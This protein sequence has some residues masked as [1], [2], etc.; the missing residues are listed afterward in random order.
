MDT[1]VCMHACL[2]SAGEVVSVV[3]VRRLRR[4]PPYTYLHSDTSQLLQR[5]LSGYW[6]SH[7][8]ASPP[9]C[10]GKFSVCEHLESNYYNQFLKNCFP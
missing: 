10:P 6:V 7:A 9:A 1:P 4:G 5:G 8:L 2:Q 3:K